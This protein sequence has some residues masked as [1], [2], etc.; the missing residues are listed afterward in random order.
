GSSLSSDALAPNRWNS[1]L[2]ASCP[3]WTTGRKRTASAAA[4]NRSVSRRIIASPSLLEG[5]VEPVEDQVDR[6][7]MGGDE[8]LS[9]LALSREPSAP[10]AAF[11][12]ARPARMSFGARAGSVSRRSGSPTNDEEPPWP[13]RSIARTL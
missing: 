10:G 9:G 2:P 8:R 7:G 4:A 13:R 1:Q 5:P 12:Q 3:A 11:S 6:F